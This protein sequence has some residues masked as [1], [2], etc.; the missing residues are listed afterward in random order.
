MWCD[1][2]ST[3]AVTFLLNHVNRATHLRQAI[4]P[5]KPTANAMAASHSEHDPARVLALVG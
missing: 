3:K 5:T 2:P 1:H 4:S